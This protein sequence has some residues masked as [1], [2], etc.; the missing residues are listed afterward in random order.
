MENKK[1]NF[2][3][4]IK[5]K[6]EFYK[7]ETHKDGYQSFCKSC[8]KIKRNNFYRSKKGLPSRIYFDQINSSIRN[9]FNKPKY[10]LDELRKWLLSNEKYNLLYDEWVKSNY[11]KMKVPSIDR[12]DDYKGYCF[13]NIRLITWQENKNK[14]HNDEKNG[15]NTKRLVKVICLNEKRIYVKEYYSIAD[16]S[17]KTGY[18]YNCIR[19][20]LNTN[21]IYK[22]LLWIR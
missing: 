5:L 13:N 19:R 16:A 20:A 9:G 2:C 22:G 14:F 6:N 12:L 8:I 21:K 17:R 15:I 4:K 18:N 7:D 3:N 1:C 11:N 10:S